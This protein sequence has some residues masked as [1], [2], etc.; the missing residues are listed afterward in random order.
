KPTALAAMRGVL[1]APQ[2][3]VI[4]WRAALLS[5]KAG[6]PS[7]RGDAGRGAWPF[8]R[9]WRE[10]TLVSGGRR[11]GRGCGGGGV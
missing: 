7:A 3:A 2:A 11:V 1:S 10:A 4:S 5:G 6:N 9:L 8:S